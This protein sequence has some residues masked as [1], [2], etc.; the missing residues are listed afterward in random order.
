MTSTES[1]I[2]FWSETEPVYGFLCQWFHAPI[3][4]KAKL[5]GDDDDD[6]ISYP[7]A[8][9]YM[10]H[11]KAEL[12]ND[13][14]I[15]THILATNNPAE[16]KYLARTINMS[17]DKGKRW[18]QQKYDVVEKG[19]LLKFT[20]NPDLKRRLLETEERELVETS[21]SDRVWGVGIPAGMAEAHRGS[22]GMN[23]LGQVLMKIREQLR[24]QQ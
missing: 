3:E 8:E 1:P 20:Q 9:H 14:A 24:E 21:P 15:A 6:R 13:K 16:A 12:Y 10:M 7:T 5:E 18:E 23:L 2:F 22:W 4:V 19:T 17:V 11:Q